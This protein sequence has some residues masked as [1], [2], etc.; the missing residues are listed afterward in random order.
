MGQALI[1]ILI[2][3]AVGHVVGFALWFG[4]ELA[5]W[6][7]RSPEEKPREPIKPKRD[8]DSWLDGLR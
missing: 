5:T 2:V 6:L 3:L 8:D 1:V 4:V 7:D